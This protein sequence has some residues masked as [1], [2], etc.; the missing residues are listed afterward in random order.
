MR[1]SRFPSEQESRIDW[2]RQVISRQ[3][4]TRV[5]LTQFCRQMGISYRKFSYWRQRLREMDAASSGSRIT[6]PSGSPKPARAA[7]S[8]TPAAFV[9][10]SIIDR[11]ATTTTALEIELANGCS[12][13]LTGSIDPALLRAAI[14]AAGEV[15]N[16]GRGG[17]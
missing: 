17:H 4:S 5:P 2:W 14:M 9:P 3:Q 15:E 10:V 16:L 12:V 1:E 11:S 13:R 8:D 6:N 7:V